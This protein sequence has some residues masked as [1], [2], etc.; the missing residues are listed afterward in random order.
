MSLGA[1][2]HITP[3]AALQDATIML[4]AVSWHLGTYGCSPGLLKVI[5]RLVQSDSAHL[6]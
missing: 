4:T 6:V 2:V 1:S 3:T 5:T